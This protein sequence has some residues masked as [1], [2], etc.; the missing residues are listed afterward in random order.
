MHQH[1]ENQKQ[2]RSGR[3][4]PGVRFEDRVEQPGGGQQAPDQ[5]GPFPEA[6][7]QLARMVARS[8]DPGDQ[9]QVLIAEVL[10]IEK[11]FSHG[12][13]ARS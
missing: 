9:V 5:L 11:G 8:F 10:Q 3:E 4:L 12:D 1:P 7:P 2:A 13:Q 6:V